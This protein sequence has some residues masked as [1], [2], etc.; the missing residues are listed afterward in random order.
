MPNNNLLVMRTINNTPYAPLHGCDNDGQH[1]LGYCLGREL[2]TKPNVYWLPGKKATRQGFI[3]LMLET[4]IPRTYETDHGLLI[5]LFSGHGARERAK[6]DGNEKDK[7]TEFQVPYDYRT[8]G[9][10]SDSELAALYGMVNPSWRVRLW[11]DCCHSG[12]SLRVLTS[13]FSVRTRKALPPV[14]CSSKSLEQTFA[15]RNT[16]REPLQNSTQYWRGRIFRAKD[17]KVRKQ[18]VRELWELYEADHFQNFFEHQDLLAA[19]GCQAAEY[20]MDAVI[21]DVPQGAFSAAIW[22]ALEDLKVGATWS[23]VHQLATRWLKQNGFTEQNPILQTTA[24]HLTNEPFL[25]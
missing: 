6:W 24:P 12:D 18:Y 11:N 7:L 17:A 2:V 14:L 16:P 22:A 23:Q 5:S 25:S 1:M 4:V 19:Q 9:Y 3:D 13:F 20:S 8:K 10:W 15:Y 21:E